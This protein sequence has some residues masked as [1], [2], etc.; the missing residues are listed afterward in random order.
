LVRERFLT[1][2]ISEDHAL[3]IARAGVSPFSDHDAADFAAVM[4]VTQLRKALSFL[5][6]DDPT[7]TTGDTDAGQPADTNDTPSSNPDDPGDPGD[8]AQAASGVG[9]RE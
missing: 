5:P 7:T 6:P 2:A 4:T 1:G 3:E 8:S 9:V